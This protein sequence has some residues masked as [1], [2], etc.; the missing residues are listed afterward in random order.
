MT[1]SY[2]LDFTYGFYIS[3]FATASLHSG[4]RTL[5]HSGKHQGRICRPNRKSR[6][7][8]D[9]RMTAWRI[10]QIFLNIVGVESPRRYN[11]I[12]GGHQHPTTAQET[13]S[14]LRMTKISHQAHYEMTGDYYVPTK[15]LLLASLR[16]GIN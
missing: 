4:S 5:A 15:L 3:R 2:E 10:H 12:M 13:F 7:R 6:T 1:G 16:P 8:Y 11:N 9:R 14:Y